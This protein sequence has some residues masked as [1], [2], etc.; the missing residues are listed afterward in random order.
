M[1][2]IDIE[3][4]TKEFAHLLM[5][6]SIYKEYSEQRE[7]IRKQPEIYEKVNEFRQ[8]N[9]ELQNQAEDDNLLEKLESF[10]KEYEALRENPLVEDF[11][12]AEL[13]FCRMMQDV[14]MYLTT[15]LDFE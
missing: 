12:Q 13:A 10:E 1:T 3:Q 14:N 2:D 4:A 6:S 9:F 7:K 8:R 15:E 5:K 11:L